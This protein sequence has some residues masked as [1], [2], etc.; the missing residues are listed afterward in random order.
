MLFVSYEPHGVSKA[1]LMRK[2]WIHNENFLRVSSRAS[3]G[4]SSFVWIGEWVSEWGGQ[5]QYWHKVGCC[6]WAEM[7]SETNTF[8][9]DGL[10]FI[11]A[12]S[13]FIHPWIYWT[14]CRFIIDSPETEFIARYCCII[15]EKRHRLRGRRWKG[16]FVRAANRF[17]QRGSPG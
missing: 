7:S 17:F 13:I 10:H 4:V 16:V 15:A 1:F 14:N 12:E 2:C 6:M 11:W 9:E 3:S 8:A 5:R